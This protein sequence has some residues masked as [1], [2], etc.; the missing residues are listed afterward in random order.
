LEKDLR[1]IAGIIKGKIIGK[2]NILITGINSIDKALPGEITF[3]FDNSYRDYLKV[4]RASAVLVAEPAD[5]YNGSQIIV[6]DP[7]LAYARIAGIFAPSISRYDGISTAAVISETSI[8]GSNTSIY[9]MVYIG[10]EAVIGDGVTLYPGIFIGDRVRVGDRTIIY[11]NVS[12]LRDCIIGKDVI[13]HAGCVIGSDGFGYVR[14]G[15]ENVKVPQL[16]IV[17]IDDN[18][19]IGANTTIDRAANGRTWIQKGVKT[20]NLVQIAHNVTI[21]EDSILVAQA[22]IS[23]SVR[24]GRQVIIGGQVGIKDHVEIGD[25]AVIG[26]GAGVHKSIPSGEVV[27]GDPSLPHRLWMRTRSLITR[28]PEFNDRLK[29]L[30]KIIKGQERDKE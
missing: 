5:D 2:D 8:I 4:T 25:N 3:F 24:I 13:I 23:G 9:P 18:V 28:L 6:S 7:K 14:D 16:G 17:Q 1:E 11:P 26:S 21:G 10:K 20:D 19:E 12:I 15:S 27:L 30:E 29:N 22:G